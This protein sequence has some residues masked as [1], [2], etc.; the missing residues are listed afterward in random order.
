AIPET[1]GATHRGCATR[2]S[3]MIEKILF[4]VDFSPACVAIAPFVK[5]AATVF[6]SRVSMLYVCDLASHNGFELYLRSLQE[7]AEEH[8]S[9]AQRKLDSFLESDFPVSGCP[10]IIRSGDTVEQ[11]A[12]VAR[13]DGFDLIIM[14]THAGR[15]RRMLLGSTTAKVLDD[16]ACPVLTTEHAEVIAPRPLEHREWLCALAINADSERVLDLANRGASAAGAKLSLI[17]VIRNCGSAKL[18]CAEEEYARQRI[19]EL[20]NSLGCNAMLHIFRGSVKDALL[21]SAR[22][23]SADVLIVGRPQSESLGRLRDLTY[24]VIRDALCPVLSV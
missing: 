24:G 1:S 20:Q 19:T 21:D 14:P 23:S 3:F 8:W 16:A 9:V 2:R 6:Q 15:F 17:H 18:D 7:I 12:T 13:S 22:Q 10:R 11:I 4:P 5:R